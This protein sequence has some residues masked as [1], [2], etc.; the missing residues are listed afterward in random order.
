MSPLWASGSPVSML[1][2]NGM[3]LVWLSGRPRGLELQCGVRTGAEETELGRG[4]WALGEGGQRR[5]LWERRRGG[6]EGGGV[7]R[8]S[9]HLAGLCWVPGHNGE[10]PRAGA[11]PSR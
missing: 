9:S 1:S 11:L 8:V 10:G 6:E 7:S 4:L 5:G 3:R 2:E